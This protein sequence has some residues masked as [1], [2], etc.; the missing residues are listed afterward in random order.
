ME[1]TKDSAINMDDMGD[2]FDPYEMAKPVDILKDFDTKYC[3]SFNTAK[4]WAEK[5]TLLEKL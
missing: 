1:E 3:E 4:N 2:D 5:V